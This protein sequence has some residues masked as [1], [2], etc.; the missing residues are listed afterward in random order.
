VCSLAVDCVGCLFTGFTF[1]MT[2]AHQTFTQ[3]LQIVIVD[4]TFD[5]YD[6]FV[7]AAQ[8]GQIGLHF[9]VS[10]QSAVRLARRYR[11]DAWLLAKDLD[12]MSGF[13]LLE[14]LSPHVLQS[15]VDP[16]RSGAR[17]S[18]GDMTRGHAALTTHSGVF[19]VADA[20]CLED[21]QRALVSGVSGYLV[22]PVTLDVIRAA[23]SPKA[24]SAPK[25][26]SGPTQDRSGHG[27]R[28]DSLQGSTSHVIDD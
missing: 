24:I 6:D 2:Y 15:A 3:P 1:I 26:M 22:R 11:A 5:R 10:G 23:R 13:D 14:M 12:D 9:C 8:T 19:I 18:L 7:A 27:Q 25:A 28:T 21:E 17:I 4:S 20:Y 16:L